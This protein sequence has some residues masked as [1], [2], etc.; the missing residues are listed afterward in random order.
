MTG[1]VWWR[2]HWT[3]LMNYKTGYVWSPCST[4][5]FCGWCFRVQNVKLKIKIEFLW[6]ALS[7]RL[8]PLCTTFALAHELKTGKKKRF[9]GYTYKM[10]NWIKSDTFY[11]LFELKSHCSPSC[12]APTKIET[13]KI[14]LKAY[15][16]VDLKKKKLKIKKNIAV[17]NR[18]EYSGGCIRLQRFRV[19]KQTGAIYPNGVESFQFL[20]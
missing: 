6:I 2:F 16:E 12:F 14:R 4:R 5:E 18:L 8:L 13:Y 3:Q 19:E 11:T 9:I 20:R 7:F 10:W 17:I 15:L 1:V